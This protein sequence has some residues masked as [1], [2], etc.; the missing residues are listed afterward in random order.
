MKGIGRRIVFCGVLGAMVLGAFLAL[1]ASPATAAKGGGQ[2]CP[3]PG[4]FCTMQ[5]DPVI[6]SNGVTYS[7]ACVAYVNCATGC[8]PTGGGGGP[9]G[10]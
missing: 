2:Q 9:F 8:V 7:N 1:T 5:Y 10:L 4:I 6:C 3:R